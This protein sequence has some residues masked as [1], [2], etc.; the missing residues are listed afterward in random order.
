MTLLNLFSSGPRAQA[1]DARGDRSV[2]SE[3][4]RFRLKRSCSRFSLSRMI[5]F[6]KAVST[7]YE[8]RGRLLPDHALI[9]LLLLGLVFAPVIGLHVALAASDAG[10][11]H[12][13]ASS[14]THDGGPPAARR[15]R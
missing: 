1:A 12:A 13:A 7:P 2:A 11:L 5:F 15:H 9:L 3:Q 10:T 8:V 6:G 4:D 14:A